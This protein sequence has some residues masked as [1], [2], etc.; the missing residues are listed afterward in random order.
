M[1]SSGKEHPL[2]DRAS[3]RLR[4]LLRHPL[5]L[6]ERS[7]GGRQ[8][9]E[10]ALARRSLTANIVLE[11]NSF[12]FLRA[13]VR[14][15][16]AITI[17]LAIGAPDDPATHAEARGLSAVIVDPRDILPGRLMLAQMRERTLPVAS[18]K[19]ADMLTRKLQTAHER[20]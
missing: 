15:E 14:R 9:L 17:Q 7:F 6:P 13:F 19:F 16:S 3:L 18:A 5:A 2:G 20:L 4:E 8:M 1:R 10:Q 11:S 12:E